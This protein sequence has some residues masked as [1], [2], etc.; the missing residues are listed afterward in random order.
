MKRGKEPIIGTAGGVIGSMITLILIVV[1]LMPPCDRCKLLNDDD[2]CLDICE[3]LESESI[4]LLEHPGDLSDDDVKEY[5]LGNINLFLKDEPELKT[6]ASNLKVERS[7]FGNSYQELSFRVDDIENLKELSLY[8]SVLDPKGDLII[9]LNGNVVSNGFKRVGIAEVVLPIDYVEENNNLKISTTSGFF[10]K[11][12]YDLRDIKVRKVFEKKNSVATETFRVSSSEKRNIKDSELSFFMYCKE[13]DGHGRFKLYFNDKVLIDEPLV[14]YGGRRSI[15][16][17]EDDFESGSNTLEFVIDNGDFMFNDV[18][19]RN[20]Y[21]ED[22]E[23]EYEY[24]FEVD[25]EQYDRIRGGEDV[26]LEIEFDGDRIIAEVVINGY[27]IGI[28]TSSDSFEKDITSHIKKGDNE[29]KIIPDTDFEI[30]ELKISL[31]N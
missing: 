31:E 23:N 6:L 3:D 21:D 2:E 15:E 8:F 12:H 19:V 20:E 29:F 10:S 7:I 17:N 26:I 13:L 5:E 16:L 1:A 25:D 4:L 9:E 11:N 18:T 14:C 30:D 28:D 27:T 22:V 24:D